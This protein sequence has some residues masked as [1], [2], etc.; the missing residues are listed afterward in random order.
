MAN[1]IRISLAR[2]AGVIALVPLISGACLSSAFA[3]PAKD[4]GASGVS[5]PS[6]HPIGGSLTDFETMELHYRRYSN[7]ANNMAQLVK[8]LNQKIQDV[9][10]AAKTVEAKSN[11]QNKRI[12]ED[13]LRQLENARTS[14]SHQYAQLQSQMQNEYRNYAAI[15]SNLKAK[16]DNASGSKTTPETTKDVKDKS[17]KGKDSKAK[18]AKAKDSN[19]REPKTKNSQINDPQAVEPPAK[20]TRLRDVETEE[21]RSRRDAAKGLNSG[22]APNLVR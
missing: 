20:A 6:S 19:V 12:L 9:S 18:T 4:V 17:A 22:Q 11:S 21:L 7:A 10:L 2:Y 13:K 8:Q 15:S 1:N 3:E 5:E 14:S 16:Y